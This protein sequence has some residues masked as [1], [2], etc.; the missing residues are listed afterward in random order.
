MRVGRA[1]FAPPWG[2]AGYG[3][4][5]GGCGK[6]DPM[7]ENLPFPL[8]VAQWADVWFEE[9]PEKP[10]MDEFVQELTNCQN[11]LL[12]Y[13]RAL[14][15]NLDL[16]ADIRQAVNLILW[17]KRENFEPGTSFK[18]WAFTVAQFEV[19]NALR[20]EWRRNKVLLNPTTLEKFSEELPDFINVLPERREALRDCLQKL[21]VKDKELVNHHYWSSHKLDALA[22]ATHR[23]VGTL[24]ARL[25]QIRG[26]LRRCI[27]QQLRTSASP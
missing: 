21:T 25:F 6:D 14:C 26:A 8:N 2:V 20:K 1:D 23:S 9:M 17:R 22:N 18:H 3:E 16:A 12:F 10:Y 5:R 7:S 13:I 4:E 15:G 11:D 24:K 19:R 27:N